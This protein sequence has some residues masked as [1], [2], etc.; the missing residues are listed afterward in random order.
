MYYTFGKETIYE[1]IK[2]A[3]AP[4][5]NEKNDI[6]FAYNKY[7]EKSSIF[8]RKIDWTGTI[9]DNFNKLK[10]VSPTFSKEK[11][12]YFKE[13]TQYLEERIS[14]GF[15]VDALNKLKNSDKDIFDL[16]NIL[17][18]LI[19]VNHLQ[20]YTNGT[21][22]DTFGLSIM[23][24]K[25]EF[26][27]QDFIELVFHQV[28]HMS[29][30]LDDKYNPHMSNFNKDKMI[31]TC[32]IY[33]HGGNAFPAYIAFHSYMVGV[34]MLCFREATDTLSF[35]GNYHGNTK[36]IVRVT[37]GFQDSLIENKSLFSDRAICILEKGIDIVSKF[38]S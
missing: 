2:L 28:V 20:S 9:V 7:L 32:L 12:L 36:R 37:K 30:F 25:D 3:A 38:Q 35:Q 14:E 33:V 31:D 8:E 15:F 11:S 29:L 26:I 27:D 1:N 21:L 5:Y 10:L 16:T 19:V 24:F 22:D 13:N 6:Q 17:I 18:K 4:F 23:N 34:E